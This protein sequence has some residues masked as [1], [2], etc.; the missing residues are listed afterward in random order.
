VAATTNV[1]ATFNPTNFPIALS[2]GV[3]N[4]AMSDEHRKS[5]PPNSVEYQLRIAGSKLHLTGWSLYVSTLWCLK[6]C[7]AIFYTRLTY[8][9]A[10]WTTEILL[11]KDSDGLS[12]MRIRIQIAYISIGVSYVVVMGVILGGCQPFH[13]YWQIYPNPGCESP[14]AVLVHASTNIVPPSAICMPAVSPLTCY[15]VVILNTLTDLYLLHIPILV[16]SP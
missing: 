12:H 3:S 14:V 4:T 15:V 16:R 7:I 13:R 1:D 6:L 11:T 10:S 9:F 8:A 5:L 2:A